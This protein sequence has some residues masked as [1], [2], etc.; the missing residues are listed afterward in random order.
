MTNTS[1]NTSQSHGFAEGQI[2]D[3]LIAQSTGCGHSWEDV[4]C[5]GL[6]AWELVKR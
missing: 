2:V 1:K 5:L 6:F 3:I 4:D